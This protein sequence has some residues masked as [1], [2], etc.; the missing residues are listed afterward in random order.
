[1]EHGA[2]S[3]DGRFIAVGHQDSSHL[4]F[5]DRL[6]PIGDIYGLSEYSHYAVF[7]AD[8]STIAFNSCHFYDG[9]TIGVPIRLLPL[10]DA[11]TYEED[12]LPLLEDNSRVFAA[13]SRDDE[14]IIGDAYGYIRAFDLQGKHRWEQFVGSSIGDIDISADGKTLVV[15][16]YAGFI[17][18]FRLDA[19]TS[20]PHQIGT[21]SHLEE[22]RWIFW[23]NEPRPLIW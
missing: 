1:M 15:S 20:A 18:I 22:R 4:V 10:L 17:S 7:S 6:E 11:D 5:N 13:V 9:A 23:K 16:T 3:R 14:F 21:G 8:L 12:E 2:V 19:G